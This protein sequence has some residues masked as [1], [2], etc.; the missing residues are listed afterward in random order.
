MKKLISVITSF[1]MAVTIAAASA[2]TVGTA[3]SPAE[4]E[5]SIFAPFDHEAA[6]A[7]R[8]ALTAFFEKNNIPAHIMTEEE[9]AA[10]GMYERHVKRINENMAFPGSY[11]DKS[12]YDAECTGVLYSGNESYDWIMNALMYFE[13]Q[14]TCKI[15]DFLPCYN[16]FYRYDDPTADTGE[17]KLTDEETVR[18]L[19]KEWCDTT[20]LYVNYHE[21]TT[22]DSPGVFAEEWCI[23]YL[24][25]E[26]KVPRALEELIA[27]YNIDRTLIEYAIAEGGGV[28]VGNYLGGDL[29]EDGN[30]NVSDVILLSRYTAE[31]TTLSIS[32]QGMI[33]A[34]FNADTFA[35]TD[36]IAAML[37]N[38]AGL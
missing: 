38:L 3:I 27:K 24:W 8:A 19:V 1:C 36:D 6:E 11:E 29:N 32:T 9:E 21:Y 2:P 23:G 10:Y 15:G 4:S 7:Y 13:I 18:A 37:K 5:P 31:D 30:F 26:W 28:N 22:E 33:N 14:Y 35:D 12:Y 17:E 16:Y 20:D 34:D 25:T